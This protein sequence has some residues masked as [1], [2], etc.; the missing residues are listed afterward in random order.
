MRPTPDDG[1]IVPVVR[2]H[3]EQFK[4][5]AGWFVADVFAEADLQQVFGSGG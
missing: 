3:P 1:E 2:L 5:F 4:F